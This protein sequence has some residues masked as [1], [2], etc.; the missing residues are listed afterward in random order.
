VNAINQKDAFEKMLSK[1]EKRKANT[2][3]DLD[4]VN[5]GKKTIRTI[6]KDEKDSTKMQ[7]QIEVTAKELEHLETLI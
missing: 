1:T 6:F 4:N 5:A 7:T 2:E 3:A